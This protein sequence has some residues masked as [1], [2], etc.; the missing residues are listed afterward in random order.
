MSIAPGEPPIRPEDFLPESRNISNSEVTTFLSCKRQY[1]FAFIER[2]GLEPLVTPRHLERGTVGHFIQEKYIEGRLDGM[3]HERALAY[4]KGNL[5]FLLE[6]DQVTLDVALEAQGLVERYHAYHQGWPE[7]ELLGTEQRVDL[8]LTDTLSIAIRYD[9]KFRE[10]STDKV[11]I[12]DWKFTYDFWTGKKHAMHPQMPKYIAVMRA[13]NYQVDGAKIFEIRTRVLGKEKASDPKNLW[14]E[15][16]FYPT[17]QELNEAIRQHVQASLEIEKHRA[18]D[19]DYRRNYVSIPTR[20]IYGAC[21]FCAFDG[22]CNALNKGAKD[23]SL[24]LDTEFK[25]NT[26]GYNKPE[27]QEDVGF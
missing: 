14:R 4:A 2:G 15:T 13:N 17:P 26:Y 23:I 6:S 22:P 10:R 20:N 16:P 8:K 24:M 21:T 18:L 7:W 1:D 27:D 3:N 19:D 11:Y 12:G 5:K 25:T 9:L